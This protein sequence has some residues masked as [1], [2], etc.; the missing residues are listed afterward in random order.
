MVGAQRQVRELQA[1]SPLATVTALATT[2]RRRETIADLEPAQ[3]TIAT[4]SA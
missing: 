1:V 4:S 3:A 2:S